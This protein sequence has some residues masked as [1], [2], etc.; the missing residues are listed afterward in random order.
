MIEALK[1]DPIGLVRGQQAQ[2]GRGRRGGGRA[3]EA[4][5]PSAPAVGAAQEAL[6]AEHAPALWAHLAN[7]ALGA[8]LVAS[9][10][11]YGLFDPVAPL[12][13][14]PAAGH[15]LAAPRSAT[16]GSHGARS[17]AASLS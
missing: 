9:P 8:W 12:P 11:T 17:S 3:R 6:K 1:A 14:P 4:P 16:P 10:F 13:P 15:E 5:L 2:P 7:L